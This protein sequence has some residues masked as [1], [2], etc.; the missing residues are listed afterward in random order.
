MTNM[1][2]SQKDAQGS[3]ALSTFHPLFLQ[4]PAPA[5][6]FVPATIVA[7]PS[8]LTF[9]VIKKW[10]PGFVFNSYHLNNTSMFSTS[11]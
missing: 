6:G 1:S 8:V 11:Y 2:S 3:L 9:Y 7:S 5:G 10:T 4:L